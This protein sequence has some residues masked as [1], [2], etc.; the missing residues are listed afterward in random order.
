[1]T[2]PRTDHGF[3]SS[4][5]TFQQLV[6]DTLS[7]AKK[8]GASDA[9]AEVS[10]GVG[11]SVSV[12]MGELENVE[13]NRDKSLG[14]SV[15]LGQSRG[16]ASTSDFSPAALKQT[17]QAAYDIARFTA[18]DPAAGLPDAEDLATP[19]EVARDLDLFHPWLIDA[20]GRRGGA[21]LRSCSAVD[22]QAHHQ[23]RRR[24]MLGAAIAFL[25]RQHARLPW[26]LCQF[27]ALPVGLTHRRSRPGHA[28]RRLV[29]LDARRRRDVVAGSGGPI[30]R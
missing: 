3:A 17:V 29:Q 19:D 6:D 18:A 13:R 25:G 20:A 11:L 1:M 22:Q 2:R 9:G 23:Q 4:R 27:P 7:L 8:M 16:N 28:A 21:P 24:W 14:V 12:R 26:G 10:E 15:Y 5:E 30:R